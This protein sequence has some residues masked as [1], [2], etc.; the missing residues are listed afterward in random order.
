MNRLADQLCAGSEPQSGREAPGPEAELPGADRRVKPFAPP[1]LGDQL[2]WYF[3]VFVTS[4]TNA[5]AQAKG[6]ELLI[7]K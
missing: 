6:R 3:L 5:A 1:P 4:Q 7:N 2:S